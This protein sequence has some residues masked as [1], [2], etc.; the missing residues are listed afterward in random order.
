MRTP[1]RFDGIL[2]AM[3]GGWFVSEAGECYRGAKPFYFHA[4]MPKRFCT[5]SREGMPD[6]VTEFAVSGAYA[7][8]CAL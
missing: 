7:A 1:M 5:I 2:E 6:S 8:I 3:G 4:A